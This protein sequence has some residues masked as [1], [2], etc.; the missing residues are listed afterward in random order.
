MYYKLISHMFWDLFQLGLLASMS[1]QSLSIMDV[2][3]W[4][5]GIPLTTNINRKEVASA[6]PFFF[7][8][9]DS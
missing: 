1:L 5:L 4:H 6:M 2:F 3:G 9:V 8:G 7:G